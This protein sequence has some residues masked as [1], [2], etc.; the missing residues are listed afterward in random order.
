MKQPINKNIII[1]AVINFIYAW[2]YYISLPILA[3]HFNLDSGLSITQVGILLGTPPIVSAIIGYLSSPIYKRFGGV[4]C[5]VSSLFM[6]CFVFIGYI[7]LKSFFLLLII[8]SIQGISRILW[9]PIIKNLF[10]NSSKNGKTQELVFRIKYITICL[11]AI[12]GPLLGLYI[13]KYSKTNNLLFSIIIFSLLIVIIV[14][15]KPRLNNIT[16][17]LPTKKKIKTNISNINPLLILYILGGTTVF[18][19]FSQ[20]ETIFSL[21]LKSISNQPERL[22][23][24]LLI[25]NSISGLILQFFVVIISKK[26]SNLQGVIVGN[27]FFAISFSL[28]AFSKGNIF[29]LILATIIFSFGEAFSV[30]GG[31]IL[32]NEIAPVNQ[33]TLYFGLAEFRILGFSLGPTFAAFILE[34]YGTFNMYISSVVLILLASILYLIPNI[35]R[36]LD[37]KNKIELIN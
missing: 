37:K 4:N 14:L 29:L 13:S 9:E 28:F 12:L 33:K 24:L 17:E 6:L 10:V 2:G 35:K 34:H 21:S 8:S 22:F 18:I 3:L 7:Y 32:I 15:V 20:F 23:S 5:M 26:I 36:Q 11:G 30:P 16:K 19:V 27:V 31:D 1:L 25:L